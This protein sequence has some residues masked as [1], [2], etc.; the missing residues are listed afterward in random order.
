M[1]NIAMELSEEELESIRLNFPN[2]TREHIKHVRYL[3][4]KARP[5]NWAWQKL[6]NTYGFSGD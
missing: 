6:E 1:K 2:N 3:C 5:G 4:K